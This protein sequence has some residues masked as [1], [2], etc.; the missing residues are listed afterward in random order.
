M[1]GNKLKEIFSEL[2][3]SSERILKVLKLN[4]SDTIKICLNGMIIN[5]TILSVFV[6]LNDYSPIFISSW[7]QSYFTLKFSDQNTENFDR[8][9]SMKD[10]ADWSFYCKTTVPMQSC[11]LLELPVS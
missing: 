11:C 7:L 10:F 6:R 2:F 9:K 8:V 1:I 3:S 4:S 5:L